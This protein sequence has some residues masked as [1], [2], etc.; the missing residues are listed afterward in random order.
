MNAVRRTL[1]NYLLTCSRDFHFKFI[2]SLLDF[3]LRKFLNLLD[4]QKE[5]I[6][7]LC[8][9]SQSLLVAAIV[10]FEK[11]SEDFLIV[12]HLR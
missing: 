11:F 1:W 4:N 3:R 2:D 6:S 9:L 7:N 12:F 8:T 10:V 5:V